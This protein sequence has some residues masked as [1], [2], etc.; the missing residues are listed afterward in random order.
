MMAKSRAKLHAK[1]SFGIVFDNN[2]SASLR[3]FADEVREKALR[4]AA[5]AAASVLYVEMKAR[6]E[7]MKDTGELHDS[8]YHWHDENKSDKNRQV[9]AIG[10]NKQKA[11][12]WHMVE[13]GTVKSAAQPYIRPT[14]DGKMTEAMD[15]ARNRLSEKIA[16]LFI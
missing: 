14:A 9:Y 2:I 8:I 16:E 6:T 11:G 1:E 4:S 3:N 12:H 7:V 13:F 10:P 15:A 5:Y